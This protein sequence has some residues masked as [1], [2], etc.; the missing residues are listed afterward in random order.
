MIELY[1]YF[2]RLRKNAQ[3]FEYQTEGAV[4]ADIRACL[5]GPVVVPA[6]SRASLPT[7]WAVETPFGMELQIR[8]RS[9][10]SAKMGITVI[11]APGTIDHDYTGEIKVVLINLGFEDYVVQP[12]E[13]IA[14][15]VLCPVHRFIPV[16][17]ENDRRRDTER[18]DGGFGSTGRI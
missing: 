3:L 11:N 6:M 2:T 7:G 8:P 4:G 13:R 10:L 17:V 16:E 5:D 9:G 14:Q 18:N 1:T 15:A 12:G